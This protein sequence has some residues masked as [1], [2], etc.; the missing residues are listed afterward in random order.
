MPRYKYK[1]YFVCKKCNKTTT[2]IGTCKPMICSKCGA[3]KINLSLKK[4]VEL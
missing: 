4:K 2:K 3:S 1:G